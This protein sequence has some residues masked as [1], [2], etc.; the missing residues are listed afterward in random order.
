MD[1]VQ[2]SSFSGR[3]IV[4]SGASSGIGR[5]TAGLLA[6]KG[7]KLVLFG[8]NRERLEI[9]AA[10]AG[11]ENCHVCVL[12]LK[13]TDE[14]L[15]AVREAH[16]KFGH[17]Y[18]LCHAAGTVTTLPLSASA[19]AVVDDMLKVN[20][21]A[22]L[23]LC[24]A[25]CRREFLDPAG[26]SILFISSIYAIIGKAGEIAYS[27]AKGAIGSAARAMA[28]ELAR[29]NVRVNVLAPGMVRTEMTDRA[30][31]SLSKQQRAA[32]E[33]SH[34]LGFGST[35]DVAHAAAFLLS[36]A[37]KWITGTQLVIDGGCSAH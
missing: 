28:I 36:P 32:L 21:V 30:F 34:P 19:P 8:R 12:D 27:G 14:I 16:G 29:R 17:F 13:R 37:S 22:G 15:P 24:R 20:Y 7:A 11:A 5:A 26:G 9:A 33:E 6:R 3:V 2:D 4:V 25:V 10:N 1:N 23:E 35:E 31:A 18:G